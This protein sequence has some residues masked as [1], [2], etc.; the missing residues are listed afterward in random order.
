M[1]NEKT[2]E[3]P[4]REY[5][6]LQD[7]LAKLE[8]DAEIHLARQNPNAVVHDPAFEAW[9]AEV[10]RPA[11]VRTQEM[12]NKLWGTAS[13]RYRCRLEKSKDVHES[14]RLDEHFPL[15]ISANSDL[16]AGA[17]YLQL[18]GIR[19]HIHTLVAEPI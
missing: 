17:R 6:D 14:V 9:K 12:A 16:E 7:R 5:Q 4:A 10:A 1:A 2:I 15:E 11:A 19:S 8:K 18:M 13:P 3:V